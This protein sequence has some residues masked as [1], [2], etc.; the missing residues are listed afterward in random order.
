M[1]ESRLPIT[2]NEVQ[3]VFRRRPY[4]V[5]VDTVWVEKG[6]IYSIGRISAQISPFL[7]N[8]AVKMVKGQRTWRILD[9]VEYLPNPYCYPTASK[10][11]LSNG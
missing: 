10:R 6:K 9:V 1:A 2:P 3:A 11:R 5:L 4:L 8:E 7:I